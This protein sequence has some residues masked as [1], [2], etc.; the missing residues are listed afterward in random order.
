MAS[1]KR[2]NRGCRLHILRFILTRLFNLYGAVNRALDD[3]Q[4]FFGTKFQ[5]VADPLPPFAFLPHDLRVK[6][7]FYGKPAGFNKLYDN[8]QAGNGPL[9][10]DVGKIAPVNIYFSAIALR[11]M[12]FACRA[13][14]T[15]EPKVSK[16]G[17]S[18][19]FAI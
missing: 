18:S 5:F 17:Q 14:F 9:V 8:R 1:H 16:P 4:I 10:F 2:E 7:P 12:R 15:S 19:I 11:E 6:I 3:R 13:A